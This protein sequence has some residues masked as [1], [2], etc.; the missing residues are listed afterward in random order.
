M[1]QW[2]KI[3]VNIFDDEKISIIESM[4]GGDALIVIWFKLLSLAG[5]N[6]DSGL[7]YVVRDLPYD[8][9]TLST[10]IRRPLNTVKLALNTFEK[11]HMIDIID[12]VISISNWGKHQSADALDKIR[13]NN[14]KRVQEH[15][16]KQKLLIQDKNKNKSKNKRGNV[17]VTLQKNFMKPTQKEVQ[18]YLDEKGITSFDGQYF[19]DFYESK[20]WMIGSSKMKNWKAA[21]STWLKRSGEKNEPPKSKEELV[22]KAKILKLNALN[23]AME[24]RPLIDDEK[25]LL[26]KLK[27]ELQ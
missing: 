8:E 1:L 3:S 21:V 24:T 13:E 10:V 23:E 4:P 17:T 20:G 16:E 25:K 11:L 2:I 9:Q 18:D 6:N 22:K 14:R 27:Q 15:R 7:I 19:C 26:E 5:K 12:G